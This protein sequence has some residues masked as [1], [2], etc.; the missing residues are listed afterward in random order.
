M[1]QVKHIFGGLLQV[2]SARKGRESNLFGE[3]IDFEDVPL[4]EGVR[5]IALVATIVLQGRTNVPTNL[6]MFAE[7]GTRIGGNVGNDL[8]A[9]GGKRSTI[10]IELTKQRS[11]SRERRMDARR[12]EEIEGQCRLRKET[13]PFSERELGVNGAKNGHKMVFE[14]PNGTF[15][16]IDAM[17]FGRNTL[18][19]DLVLG[20][21]ILEVL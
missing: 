4:M 8:S 7:R 12:T 17:F 2:V 5:E 21:G 14:R 13:I 19:L 15:G 10:E 20:E 16:G 1:Q 3:N 11:M 6:A 18:E 9:Q